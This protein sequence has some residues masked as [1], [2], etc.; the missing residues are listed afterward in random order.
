[1]QEH[2]FPLRWFPEGFW[3]SPQPTPPSSASFP[4]EEGRDPEAR[5]SHK[6]IAWEV[7]AHC[8]LGR[9]LPGVLEDA[10]YSK[11]HFRNPHGWFWTLNRSVS[12]I[13]AR[14]IGSVFGRSCQGHRVVAMHAPGHEIATTP[15]TMALSIRWSLVCQFLW[16]TWWWQENED[17][18]K[19]SPIILGR[20]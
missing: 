9:A 8:F 4:N 7:L 16:R 20:Y 17:I 15:A 18:F 13:G 12:H 1:M 14:H 3:L 11:A 2:P 19:I 5:V 10:G 6:H